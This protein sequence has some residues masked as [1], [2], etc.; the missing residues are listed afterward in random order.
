MTAPKTE[1]EPT[2]GVHL[3]RSRFS[4]RAGHRIH[5]EKRILF[6]AALACAPALVIA[7]ILLWIGDHE[8]KTKLTI[9]VLVGLTTWA[10]LYALMQEAAFP[11]RTLSNLL[12]AM[13]EGDYSMRA[14]GASYDDALGEVAMEINALGQTL[15]EE[16]LGAIEATALLSRVMEAIDVAVFAFDDEQRL[17]L[18]NQRGEDLL[19][20]DEKHLFGRTADD[21]GL[22]DCLRGPTPRLIEATFPGGQGRW[23]LRRSAFR[24]GGRR[25]VL[26]VLSDLT[27]TLRSEERQAWQRLIQVLR[28]EINN[29][30]API[31]SLADSLAAI[32]AR[33][34]RPDDWEEDLTQGLAVIADR[35]RSLSRFMASY[36][37]LARL[38]EPKLRPLNVRSWVQRVSE[39]QTRPRVR[40]DA[41]PDITIQADGDQLDQLLINLLR[42]AADAVGDEDGEVGVSWRV[43]RGGKHVLV[44]VEDN[45][46][47]ISNPENLFVP[48]FTTKPQGSGIG[49]VLCR[50]IAEAHG[51]GINLVNRED[52]HGCRAVL[53][54]PLSPRSRQ[55]SQLEST[56]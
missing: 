7:G 25:H 55:D 2:I 27:R 56:G 50:Q 37:Q 9:T 22:V 13:R 43:G 42:N 17:R 19:E 15:R 45:G 48:F 41:G 1:F 16:R 8:P 11:L 10:F 28:H 26:L 12:A 38:P 4:R 29:S 40:I 18:V 32:V 36:T 54:L 33:S 46:P 51:G 24:E 5:H 20:R 39:L 52:T 31:N 30:L 3:S 14:R 44:A 35:S 6:F 34:P 49:L 23:E 47:G 53:R 21:V